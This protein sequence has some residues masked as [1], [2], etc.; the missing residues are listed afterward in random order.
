MQGCNMS[1]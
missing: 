1:V